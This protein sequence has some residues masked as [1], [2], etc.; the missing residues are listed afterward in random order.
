MCGEEGDALGEGA[1]K[2][3]AEVEEV[4]TVAKSAEAEE[5]GTARETA[6]AEEVGTVAK[7][8]EVEEVGTVIT[9]LNT[10]VEAFDPVMWRRGTVAM[11]GTAIK[12]FGAAVGVPEMTVCS[13]KSSADTFRAN[14]SGTAKESERERRE[15]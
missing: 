10:A 1:A 9:S 11:F 12:S 13:C 3:T 4:G 6:E 14:A 2:E 8:A 5:V 7:S 15:G